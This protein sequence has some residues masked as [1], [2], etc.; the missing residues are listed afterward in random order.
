MLRPVKRIMLRYWPRVAGCNG[1][2][3]FIVTWLLPGVDFPGQI[4]TK[5]FR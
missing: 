5:E 2:Y 4:I 3:K 1:T